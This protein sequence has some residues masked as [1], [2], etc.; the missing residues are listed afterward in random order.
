MS[1]QLTLEQIRALLM[2]A[3]ASRRLAASFIDQQSIADL[4]GY[5]AEL[6]AEAARLQGE[7]ELSFGA[8]NK[9]WTLFA[10]LLKPTPAGHA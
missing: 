7:Q 2:E 10:R 5:A 6:E 8:R 4:E 3:E 1:D 9:R